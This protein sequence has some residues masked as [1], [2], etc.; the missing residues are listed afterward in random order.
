VRPLS[1]AKVG[2]NVAKAGNIVAKFFG[3]ARSADQCAGLQLAVWEAIEDGAARPDF[4]SG[5]FRSAGSAAVLGFAQEYYKGLG[6]PGD[7]LYLQ[8]AGGGGNDGQSQIASH[9]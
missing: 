1:S 7:A 2:G 5:R 3:A 8:T 9:G 4:G 6:E